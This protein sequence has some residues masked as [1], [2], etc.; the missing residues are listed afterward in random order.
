MPLSDLNRLVHDLQFPD[1]R[2][3][4]SADPDAFLAG[5]GLTGEEKTAIQ[6]PDLRAL[7]LFGANP[8]LLRFFQ[9]WNRITDDEFRAALKG[10]SFPGSTIEGETRV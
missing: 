9:H 4:Y 10:L 6:G 7:W 5:Y 1:V 3:R 8:Y 2:E